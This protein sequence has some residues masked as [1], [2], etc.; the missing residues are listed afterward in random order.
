MTTFDPAALLLHGLHL[1]HQKNKIHPKAQRY[2]HSYQKG[3]SII[4]LFQT[5]EKL[6]EATAFCESLAKDGKTLMVIATKKVARKPVSD[7]CIENSIA[8]MTNKW[9]GGFMTNFPEVSSNIKKMNDL[10]VAQDVN[11]FGDLPK[12]ERIQLEK[13]LNKITSIYGG[14][15]TLDA[16]PGAVFIIDIKK[17]RNALKE[18]TQMGIPV[19]AVVDT[20]VSPEGVTYAIPANDDAVTSITFIMQAIAQAYRGK[21]AKAKEV[22]KEVV[23]VAETASPVE[24]ETKAAEK[25]SEKVAKKPAKATTEKPTPVKAKKAPAKVKA[26]KA[27]AKAKAKTTAKK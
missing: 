13:K 19:V 16:L 9:V 11:S 24:T 4:D 15:A 25:V 14:V 26:A 2:I 18:A 6:T 5:A 17:E 20:N 27:P 10:K 23:E 1:G 22:T 3:T 8:Y 21:K 7:I 12:H